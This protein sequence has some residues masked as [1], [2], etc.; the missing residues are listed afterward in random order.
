VI[1]EPARPRGRLR[2]LLAKIGKDLLGRLVV[3]CGLHRRWLAD[4]AVVVAFH[5]VIAGHSRGVLRCSVDDFRRYC[6]FFVRHFPVATLSTLVNRMRQGLPPSGEL[7]VTFDDGYADNFEY[8]LPILR[9]HSL[10]ALFYVTSG[11][12]GSTVQAFWDA[13]AQIES[14]W[15][16]WDQLSQLVGAGHELGAHTVNHADLS[17]LTAVAVEQELA[18]SR[19]AIGGHTGA[20]PRHFAVP[21]GRAFDSLDRVAGQ[22]LSLGFESVALCR[23]GLIHAGSKVARIERWPI[24]PTGYLSPYGWIV[25]V[26]REARNWR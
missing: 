7:C 14:R 24:D 26:I 21:F 11:F 5:S 16:S 19:Q 25:D 18:G 13:E 1:H 9:E 12:I 23:G 4:K 2:V 17:Q 15:M 8:A 3:A 10:P 6:D 20:E 22:A